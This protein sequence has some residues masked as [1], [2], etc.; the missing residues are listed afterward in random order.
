VRVKSGLVRNFEL[1]LPNLEQVHKFTNVAKMRE[2]MESCTNTGI[3]FLFENE[4]E[5]V[6]LP[7]DEGTNKCPQS[8]N[9]N[10]DNIIDG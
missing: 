1:L 6:N 8:A 9:L 7:I 3:L 10:S 5:R 2:D 4:V